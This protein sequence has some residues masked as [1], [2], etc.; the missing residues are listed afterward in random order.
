MA[1]FVDAGKNGRYLVEDALNIEV[2]AIAQSLA[3]DQFS[4]YHGAKSSIIA[5]L[6]QTTDTRKI[7][8]HRSGCMIELSMLL[9]K[10]QPSWVQTIAE[11]FKF[12]FNVIMDISSLFN[13][14]DVIMDRYFEGSLKEETRE[15]RGSG[16]GLIVTFDDC[17]EIPTNFISK[18]QS[19][20]TNKTNLWQINFSP[21]M[22]A[23]SQYALHMMIPL[24]VIVSCFVRN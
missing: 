2:F 17:F 10:E 20:V 3:S 1:E 11:F 4:V 9:Q 23:N 14:Y 16:T 13:R 22:K 24:L 19:N 12:L 15:D 8:L 21:I 18:F 6:I 5:S 7:Q